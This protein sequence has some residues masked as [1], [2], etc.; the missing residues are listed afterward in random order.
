[1]ADWRTGATGALGGAGTGAAVGTALGGPVGTAIGA[2]GGGI[3]GLLG[4]LWGGSDMY[5]N[6]YANQQFM[7]PDAS[8]YRPETGGI[9]DALAQLQ[10]FANGPGVQVDQSQSQGLGNQQQALINMLQ[11]SA[12]GTGGPSAAQIQ[13]QRGLE[14]ALQQGRSVAQMTAQQTANPIAALQASSGQQA[15]L[16]RQ[17]LADAA[18]LRAQEQLAARQQLEGALG[19]ARAGASSDAAQRMQ[20][21]QFNRSQQAQALQAILGGQMNVAN[22]TMQGAMA[23]DQQRRSMQTQMRQNLIQERQ[24]SMENSRQF[25]SMMLQTAG[26]VSAGVLTGLKN[27]ANTG[28]SD[29]QLSTNPVGSTTAPRLNVPGGT[30]LRLRDM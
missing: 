3:A 20:A 24:Q 12:A 26:T 17:N 29:F 16:Q 10:G 30:Q 9:N 13:M 28:T 22:M 4:G 5:N 11:G 25:T 15:L 8:A 21:E 19:S 2:V 7:Q 18:Q 1:M 27:Q 23:L 6:P 14:Q